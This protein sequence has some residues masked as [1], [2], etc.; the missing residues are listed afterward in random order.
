MLGF[1]VDV[2][3]LPLLWVGFHPGAVISGQ[4]DYKSPKNFPFR[5][6]P[7]KPARLESKQRGL[8]AIR[9]HYPGLIFNSVYE[10]LDGGC[11][12]TFQGILS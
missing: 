4:D 6:S 12:G 8:G 5:Y 11:R 3:D 1:L 7:W 2:P 9:V 10:A